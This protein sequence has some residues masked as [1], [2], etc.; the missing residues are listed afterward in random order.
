MPWT[1]FFPSL[2]E[3]TH[4]STACSRGKNKPSF[5]E[6]RIDIR[7]S[8]SQGLRQ[9]HRKQRITLTQPS[10]KSS[11]PL[12]KCTEL[13]RCSRSWSCYFVSQRNECNLKA[14]VW[15]VFWLGS[16]TL[17]SSL[18][19]WYTALLHVPEKKIQH[20]RNPFNPAILGFGC[21]K[22][23]IKIRMLVTRTISCTIS[24]NDSGTYSSHCC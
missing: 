19:K 3:M 7:T 16:Y 15:F 4:S 9:G 6:W 5:Q 20:D 10:P 17:F 23:Y 18:I 1:Q 12:M 8:L 13:F 21:V 2:D 24:N 14:C 11:L 22:K